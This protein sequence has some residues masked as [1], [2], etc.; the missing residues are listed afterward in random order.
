MA[1][2]Q[3]YWIERQSQLF[4]SQLSEDNKFYNQQL[5]RHYQ[6][7]QRKIQSE[8][9]DFYAKYGEDNV[10]RYRDMLQGLTPE[11]RDRY[12][13]QY[14]QFVADHP[15]LSELLQLDI[16][17]YQLNRFEA[18]ELSVQ[19]HMLEL[20]AIEQGAFE[21]HLRQAYER[22][23]LKTMENLGNPSSM[24]GVSDELIHQTMTKKWVAGRNFSDSIWT[25]KVGL[26][27]TLITKLRDG[28]IRGDSYR[29]MT[30]ILQDRFKVGKFEAR[31][32]V[33]TEAAF[34]MN[35]ANAQA[36]MD[37]GI[38]R[39][40]L[41]AVLDDRTSE[42]C[43]E[44]DGEIFYFRDMRVGENAPPFHAFCR[45]MIVPVENDKQIDGKQMDF[46]DIE[47]TFNESITSKLSAEELQVYYDTMNKG[48]S[49]SKEL[50]N[51]YKGQ[52][53]LH[54]RNDGEGKNFFRMD[55][56]I[57]LDVDLDKSGMTGW[58]QQKISESNIMFFH[59]F[60]HN[61]DYIS[62][63]NEIIEEDPSQFS[64]PLQRALAEARGPQTIRRWSSD[65]IELS[66]GKTLGQTVYDE[67]Y[68]RIDEQ[69]DPDGA[70]YNLMALSDKL[71]ND[72]GKNPSSMASI[73]DLFGG[74]TENKLRLNGSVGHDLSYW[75]GHEQAKARKLGKEAFAEMFSA[76]ITN[77]SEVE[78]IEKWLPESYAM[79]K[80]LVKVL[81]GG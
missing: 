25:N 2:S 48:S 56:G 72:F 60:G 26:Q 73:S 79:Y 22:G 47:E 42:I 71:Y 33:Q 51:K 55:E 13:Q 40:S 17:I 62:Y 3:E 18:L 43:M 45:T 50:W 28:F 67:V 27:N 54:E 8:L 57:T 9:A 64:D 78:K 46:M 69:N 34:I 31:R 21:A 37:D 12:H 10:I 65:M 29:S 19:Q 4:N 80:E 76:D 16:P 7:Q 38:E 59:E 70:Q 1:K 14:N 75:E 32:L 20:G 77:S 63:R 58:G 74:A 68:K 41:S 44:M 81:I 5:T 15:E 24:F 30:T 52:I 61:I 49:E 11:E 23:Y 66:N 35:Q 53:Y 36:F 39:Y 6:E